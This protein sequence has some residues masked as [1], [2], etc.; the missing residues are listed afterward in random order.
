MC[1]KDTKGDGAEEYGTFSGVAGGEA[2]VQRQDRHE[3][4]EPNVPHFSVPLCSLRIVVAIFMATDS[5]IKAPC[6]E[7]LTSHEHIKPLSFNAVSAASKLNSVD[8]Q[9]NQ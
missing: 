6:C 3:P 7:A 4:S 1:W 5:S 2:E 9:S 8:S